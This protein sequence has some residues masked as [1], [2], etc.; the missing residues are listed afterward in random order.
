MKY[1][2]LR[3]FIGQLEARGELRRVSPPVDP[4]LEITEICDRTLRRQGP[5]LLFENPKGHEVPV[6]ANLFGTAR[7]VALGMGRESP[8]EL[9]E[10]GRLLAFLRAPDPPEGMK[11][12]WESL[13]ILRKVLDMAPKR[14]RSAPCQESVIPAAEVDLGRLPSRPAGRATRDRSSRGDW[15]SPADR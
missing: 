15:C 1:R 10:V 11:A 8:E 5:A 3:E 6:L 12:A 13:P 2:D 4:H 14:V 7:R 9:R